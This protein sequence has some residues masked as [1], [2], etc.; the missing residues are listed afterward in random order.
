MNNSIAIIP[1]RGG[2]KRIPRKNIKEFL[3][4]PILAYSVEAALESGV[5]DEV[6]VSTDDEEIAEVAK[7]YGAKFPFYRSLEMSSDMA[8]TA[9]VLVEVLDEYLKRGKAFERVCCL[10]PCA[11]F[12]TAER[13]REG[14]E[15]LNSSDA[16][17]VLPVVRFSYPPQR[18]VVIRDGELRMLY[19]E[20]YNVR[21]Q[22]LEPLYH[23]AGQFYCLKAEPLREELKLYCKRTLPM[24]LA[25]SEV[26]DIDSAGDWREAEIKYRILK[27]F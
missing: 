22:D 12:V 2:S 20:N 1:A 9:P 4:K 6:M 27:G 5:F 17:A 11:P 18:C 21:S 16:D 7:K 8:M 3:G 19:P 10:Y 23:D 25:D 14:M 24:I 15:L 13:L 26:R